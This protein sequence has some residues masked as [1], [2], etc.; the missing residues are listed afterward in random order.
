[1]GPA[2]A[3]A[4][5]RRAVRLAL[6]D[7]PAGTL[8]LVGCSGGADSLALAAATAFVAPRQGLRAGGI[9][10]DHGLQAGSV[11]RADAVVVIMRGLGLDPVAAVTVAVAGP[12]GPEAAARQARRAA[13]TEAA[14]RHGAAAVLLG[15]TRD[16]Q[17]ETVLLGL[18]RGSGARSLSGMAPVAGIWRRPL[19][20]L[21]RATVRAA[22]AQA[23]LTAWE[24]P[25]NADPVYRRSRIRHDLLPALERQLG[26]GVAAAL[27]RSGELLRADADALDAWAA[28]ER[29][30]AALP[31]H[32]EEGE[33]LAVEVLAGL[34]GAVRRRVLRAVAI[35]AGAPAT[36]LSATHVRELDR[37]VT[38]WH[39][40]GPLH[41]PGPV[42]A[43]RD[44]GRI[45]LAARGVTR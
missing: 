23:G 33:T 18:A 26:P 4:V 36:D 24:D 12:G 11:E 37:L 31:D 19:L 14:A 42:L 32:G 25:H 30:A 28:R 17:A 15:H 22:C 3:T 40:Q 29:A 16:D 44:C 39:G 5:V 45:R 10:V 34:P 1:M 41:L 6:D 20:G 38:D 9:S 27:A 43:W 35:E 2:P 7:L 8:V 21:D 13:L